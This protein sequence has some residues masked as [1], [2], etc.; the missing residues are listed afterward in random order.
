MKKIELNEKW[1]FRR[2]FLDALGMIKGC[3]GE[4]VN[5]PHDAMISTPVAPDAVSGIDSGFFKGGICN[6]TKYVNIPAEWSEECIGLYFDGV[7]MNAIVEVNGYKAC[8]QHYG[9]APFY[10]DITN[11]VK[12]GE[13]N[14]I[15]IHADT[16]LQP[17]SR[18]YTGTGLYRGAELMHGPKVHIVPN[19]I[20]AYTKEADKDYAFITAEIEV[21]NE[22]TKTRHAKVEVFLVGEDVTT[23][24]LTE[25]AVAATGQVIQINPGSTENARLALHVENPKLWDIETPDLYR[26]VAR[27]TDIG[28]FRTHFIESDEKTVDEGEVLFGIRTVT[29]DAVRGLRINGKTVKLKGGCLHHDNG[30]LG[31]VS[32]YETEA[33]KVKKLK[34]VGF[35]AIRTAH[36]PPSSALLEACDRL[37]M[38]VFDEAFDMWGIAKRSGDYSQHFNTDWEK[39]LTAFIK[40]DRSR[41]SVILW[42]TGNEIPERG[43]LNNGYSV[44]TKLADHIRG[45]DKTRPVSNATCS[46]WSGLDDFRAE[47]KVKEQNAMDDMDSSVFE[48]WIEPFV[49]GLDVVGYN[50]MEDLYEKDHEMYPDR[51]ILG[52]ENFPQEIG[53]RWP[54]VEKLPYVIGDFTWTAWDYLGEAGIGKAVYL[55]QGDPLIKKGP[56]AIMPQA[57]SPYPWRLA[58]D[59]DFDITGNITPQ[60]AYRSI[61]WGSDKTHLFSYHPDKFDKYELMSMWGFPAVEANWNYEGYEGRP[62]ELLIFTAAEEVEVFINGQSIGKKKVGTE[63]PMPGSVR[64]ETV[65]QPGKVEAVSFKNGVEISRDVLKTTGKPA[66][67]RLVPEKTEMKANGMD[68]NYIG[69]E[70]VD[71]DGRLVPDAEIDLSADLTI[72]PDAGKTEEGHQDVAKLAGFGTAR[73]IT[74][75]NYTDNETTSYRGRA[76][77]VLRSGYEK[78][79]VHFYVKAEGVNYSATSNRASC[80][81]HY[82]VGYDIHNSTSCTVSTGV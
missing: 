65:Y 48:K 58:N 60:G 45:L 26:V 9:Y 68:V 55:E 39:D 6:Y 25:N 32:L 38:Y 51:V 52:S 76:V 22:T 40:R 82:C 61:V 75:E 57:T 70:I 12:L 77:A 33:R 37:G 21:A 11:L 78:G 43:G 31:S 42:S 10:V 81:N 46:Y 73:P 47:G 50:Y 64:F 14:R 66:G 30:L 23:P 17:N 74:E 20:Y 15:T 8:M 63:R 62:I 7:M 56:W 69:I 13:E 54:M 3:P 16:S 53:F 24:V 29:A 34:E 41:P 59:A 49:N 2:G 35:N 36:N 18:W 67:I 4:E 44:A 5:L 79:T 72:E 19:G 71:E 1:T 27:V 80:F 28:E